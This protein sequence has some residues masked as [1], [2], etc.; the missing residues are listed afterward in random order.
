MSP[1]ITGILQG[2]Y[3]IGEELFR[4]AAQRI[5]RAAGVKTDTPFFSWIRRLRTF[6]LVSVG[7]VLFRADSLAMAGQ[8]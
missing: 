1:V 6:I 3:M 5:G 8:E 4:P 7:F 2:I